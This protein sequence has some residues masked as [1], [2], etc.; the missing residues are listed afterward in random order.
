MIISAGS[1][2]SAVEIEN[3]LVKHPALLEYAVIAVPDEA[4]GQVVKAYVIANCAGSDALVKE[5]QDFTR[6]NWRNTN[7]RA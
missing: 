7:S 3:T 2:M 4:R 5:L 1:T 6:E